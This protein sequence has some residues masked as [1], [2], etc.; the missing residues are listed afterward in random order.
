MIFKLKLVFTRFWVPEISWCCSFD[1]NVNYCWVFFSVHHPGSGVNY[2]ILD[3][4]TTQVKGRSD[5][6]TRSLSHSQNLTFHFQASHLSL[7]SCLQK[8]HVYHSQNIFT[9]RLLTWNC[10]GTTALV[11]SLPAAAMVLY[12]SS[13]LL[14]TSFLCYCLLVCCRFVFHSPPVVVTGLY[15]WSFLLNSCLYVIACFCIVLSFIRLLLWRRCSP[16]DPFDL[17]LA[18]MLL[19]V[20]FFIRL[21]IWWWCSAGDLD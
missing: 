17:T 2:G 11:A 9:C 13:F 6:C 20:L 7:I 14:F 18:F 4:R 21:L 8:S 10:F 15:R 1:V 12:R 5:I 16:G 19:F 3:P